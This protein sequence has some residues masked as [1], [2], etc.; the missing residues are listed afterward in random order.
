MNL[1]AISAN[2]PVPHEDGSWVSERVS[3]LVEII[4]DYDSFIDVRWIRPDQRGAD[5]PAFALVDTRTPGREYVIF[6]VKDE[7]EFD[8]RVLERLY[9]MDAAKHGNIL[10]KIESENMAVKA[11]QEKLN[12]ERLEEYTDFA[13]HLLN[14]KKHTYRHNGVKYE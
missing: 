1:D 14:S 11:I 3:R 5:D 4:R 8:G 2:L 12:K 13:Y 10:T 7:S 6:Y 9:Q